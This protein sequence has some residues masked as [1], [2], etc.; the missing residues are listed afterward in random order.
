MS[1]EGHSQP[2]C[3]GVDA[4]E[5]YASLCDAKSF[6]SCPTLCDPLDCSL[7]G[8]SV[9][10][11]SPGKNPGVG[12]HFLLHQDGLAGQNG[13]ASWPIFK[14]Q[15]GTDKLLLGLGFKNDTPSQVLRVNI[16]SAAEVADMGVAMPLLVKHLQLRSRMIWNLPKREESHFQA[17]A[18]AENKT[19]AGCCRDPTQPGATDSRPPQTWSASQCLC[20]ELQLTRLAVGRV[21]SM[22][23]SSHSR[24]QTLSKELA[25]N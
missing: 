16:S 24:V 5:V 10:G 17:R 22:D 25:A 20:W 4:R 9:H 11:D 19:C 3:C 15:S 14:F 12:Y 13:E 2:R 8:S 7:P 1:T 18:L 6:L 21:F 23:T